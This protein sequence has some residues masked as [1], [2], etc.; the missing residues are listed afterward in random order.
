[1]FILW[2]QSL[3]FS[4]VHLLRKKEKIRKRQEA[5]E[6]CKLLLLLLLLLIIIIVVRLSEVDH[7]QD[8]LKHPAFKQD[9]LQAISEHVSNSVTMGMV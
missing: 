6:L 9:P 1:M 7:Y 4:L 8:V 5:K 2:S 3:I